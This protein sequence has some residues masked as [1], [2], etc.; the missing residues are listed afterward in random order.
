VL[1]CP[2]KVSARRYGSLPAL[3]TPGKEFFYIEL[4]ARVEESVRFFVDSGLSCSSE[5][6]ALQP[7]PTVT[8][9]CFLLAAWRL[10]RTVFLAHAHWPLQSV[11]RFAAKLGCRALFIDPGRNPA[12]PGIERLTVVSNLLPGDIPTRSQPLENGPG[13][14]NA[15]VILMT[16][17]SSG[18]PKA[19]CINFE[20]LFY[21]AAG[22]NEMIP[23]KPSD[24]WLL[25][26]PLY[27]VGGLGILLR[28]FLAGGTVVLPAPN[29]PLASALLEQEISHVS[30]VPTQLLM[31]MDRR[32]SRRERLRLKAIL[33]G[34]AAVTSD[35]IH[36]A[37]ECHLPMFISYG[38][39]EMGSQVATSFIDTALTPDGR[40]RAKVLKYRDVAIAHD[41]EIL[42]RGKTLF[43]GYRDGRT[44]VD[45]MDANGWFATGDLGTLD[46]D[47]Y[48]IVRGR[49]DG[50]FISGG[51]NIQPEEIESALL[52]TGL[53]VQAL[54][55]PQHDKEYG[56]VPV[57]FVTPLRQVDVNSLAGQL[58]ERLSRILPKF[59]IP[60]AFLPLSEEVKEGGIKLRRWYYQERLKDGKT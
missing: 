37:R 27:H 30:L 36:R 14:K 29:T 1:E 20:S 31:I 39:T 59:K 47:G 6:L 18:N 58:H 44:I 60:V 21:N 34:G 46:E 50:M 24:R 53:L 13:L 19:A 15:S 11:Q 10:G 45:P 3:A 35:I 51:E 2:V 40:I 22:S 42:V 48:L 49:K 5:P 8:S 9:I 28:C 12:G 38:L 25:S 41:G 57:A 56:Q 26:L 7:A 16:S 32:I 54:V 33:L 4:N 52:E 55:V 17:G 43:Q 23:V